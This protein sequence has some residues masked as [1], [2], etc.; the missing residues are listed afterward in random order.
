MPDS[1]HQPDSTRRG[2]VSRRIESLSPSGIR[3]FF[4]LLATMEDV[5]SLGVGQ[6]DFVTPAVI[7]NAAIR[8]IEE[9]QT[10]Y[11]SN[12]GILELREAISRHLEHHYGIFYEPANE[13]IVTTG[14][15]EGLN[16]ALGALIDFGDEVLCPD[17]HF[18]AY[19]A[20][21][22]LA[23]GVVIPVPT[24]DANDFKLRAEDLE[25]RITPRTKAL[26]MGYP[27]NPTG[28]V[29]ERDDLLAVAEVARKHN[30][31]V[32]SD[33]IY[34]RLVYGH[35]H[36]CFASLPD[37]RDR[38]ILLGGFSK[39]YAMTGWRLGYVAARADLIEAMMKAHQYV[40]MS[41]PTTSQYAGLE[42]L[43]NA[44]E[45]V[46]GMINEYDRRRRLIVD[47]FNAIGLKCFEPR[48]AFYAFP[49]ISS[50]GLT[51]EA[52]AEMLLMEE[53]VAVVPGS[54]FGACGIGHVR[55]CYAQ[56]YELIEEA[57]ERMRRFV[58]RH[59]RVSR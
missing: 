49:S 36:T 6:P 26:L 14:V 42:A 24:S 11:T 18:V 41:A 43:L 27:A 19:P 4:D 28:A 47:G 45:D 1:I 5:I 56:S 32:I 22:V 20:C 52:F 17:P 39:A 54:A 48:G 3:R 12:Y 34:D 30:L 58:E 35:E 46:R 23:D 21:V 7:R 8:S 2:Q 29:M 51:D 25:E 40:M 37:M 59:R 9:G 50:T 53:R 13:I 33:E 57:L 31:F 55:A 10:H 16:V 38:T 15:S 44:E